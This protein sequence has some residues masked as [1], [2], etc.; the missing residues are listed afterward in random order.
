MPRVRAGV[1]DLLLGRKG[2]ARNWAADPGSTG[3]TTSS[4][5]V[6]CARKYSEVG[7]CPQGSRQR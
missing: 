7:R 5:A 6:A 4:V 2:Q 1:P 3:L